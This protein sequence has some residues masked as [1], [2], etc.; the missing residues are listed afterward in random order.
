VK[1]KANEKQIENSIIEFLQRKG[2]FVWKN[3]ST[4][5][6]DPTRKAFRK[7]GK[8]Q[9]SGVAD[10]IGVL[11]DGKFLAIEV[12]AAKGR[13]SDKQKSFLQKVNDCGGIGFIARS[14]EDVET[15][16]FGKVRT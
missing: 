1:L 3:Q 5:I 15:E 16:L 11:A 2:V 14:I 8:Y 12:K 6:Y 10:I 13:V 4:A 9:L 7:V